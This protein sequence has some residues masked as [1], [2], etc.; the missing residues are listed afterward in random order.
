M[1]I[2]TFGGVSISTDSTA[3]DVAQTLADAGV[4]IGGSIVMGSTYGVS[5]GTHTGTVYGTEEK[6]GAE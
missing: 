1:A 4:E 5:G 6:N 2:F 3:D